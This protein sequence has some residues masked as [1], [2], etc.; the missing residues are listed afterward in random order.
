M[1]V[2]VC[3]QYI[4]KSLLRCIC[5]SVRQRLFWRSEKDLLREEK[6]KEKVGREEHLLIS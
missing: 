6:E 3:M 2:F 4:C 5:I 1:W